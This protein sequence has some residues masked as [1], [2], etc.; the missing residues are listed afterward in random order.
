[1]FVVPVS[2]ERPTTLFDFPFVIS[3]SVY[4]LNVTK[5]PY[6]R[7]ILSVLDPRICEYFK[8]YSL[9]FEH[10]YVTTYLAS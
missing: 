6:Y 9:D 2:P 4:R 1:M 3:A 7:V 10:A 5:T 8:D